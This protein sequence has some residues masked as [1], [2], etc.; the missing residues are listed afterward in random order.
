MIIPAF[1]WGGNNPTPPYVDYYQRELAEYFS[2]SE[3][4]DYI[5]IFIELNLDAYEEGEEPIEV[6]IF[7]D[8]ECKGAAKIK[9]KQVQLNAYILNN[10][11]VILSNLEF[12][13]YFPNRTTGMVKAD[14]SVYDPYSGSY[15]SR[16]A[17][18]QDCSNYLMVSLSENE[19]Y[20]LPKVTQLCQNYP[21]PFN[22]T[23]IIEYGLVEAV[24][25]ELNIYNIKGQ[26]VKNLVDDK[27]DAGTYQ[28][29]WDGNDAN[30]I[31]VASGIYFS[32]MKAGNEVI[33]NR[34][35]LLK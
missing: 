1:N 10:P 6:A 7:V 18:A 3:Q 14:Y 4:E 23:T 26:L 17:T 35:I 12:V 29:S 24:T 9:E 33:R 25:V 28:I 32:V 34:M 8:E 11:S 15:E 22:P 16:K 19:E 13:L 5:P 31:S 27:R 30:N 2:Y 21:N 20:Q